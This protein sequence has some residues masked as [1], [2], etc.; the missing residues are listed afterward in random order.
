MATAIVPVPAKVDPLPFPTLADKPAGT[1]NEKAYQWAQRHPLVANAMDGQAQATFTNATAAYELSEIAKAAA[2][3]AVGAQDGV[4]QS[5]NA[6]TAAATAAGQSRDQSAT[7]AA[8]T[9]QNNKDFQARFLGAKNSPPTV[10]NF[11]DPLIQGAIYINA[12]NGTWNWWTGTAWQISMSDPDLTI[13]DWTS[14]QNPP[15][16]L[17]GY[18][19]TDA[20]T[21]S[22]TI[23]KA[24]Q[25]ATPRAISINLAS[26]AAANFDGTGN[27]N[28][29][30]TGLL[31]IANGGT[32]ASTAA[33]ALA[34][35]GGVSLSGAQT[36][37]GAK[38]FSSAI[39]SNG[40]VT[41]FSDAKLK[42]DVRTIDDA[43]ALVLAW[44]GVRYKRVEETNGPDYIGF[45]AQE[46]QETAPELVRTHSSGVLSVS[47]ANSTAVLVEA[48]K[49]LYKE[50][51]TLKEQK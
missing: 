20:L 44:R 41:A 35:L 32:G 5:A 6:A 36:I 13:V 15:T 23:A 3:T 16:T 37:G 8:T 2:T 24:N 28:P 45:V 39:T 48:I 38:T 18:G 46:I 17:A 34:N 11:G 22:G 25:L 19:I 7:N 21:A 42:K 31:A 12:A 4:A 47:Y 50:L 51:Q 9:V 1:Y 49:F 14:I 33:A 26:N 10:D 27:V 30:V 29:G 40:D 43:M